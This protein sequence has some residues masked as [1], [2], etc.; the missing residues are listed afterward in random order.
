MSRDLAR[1]ASGPV[2]R[3]R[4]QP[5]RPPRT[6]VDDHPPWCAAG[7]HCTARHGAGEHASIP[8]VWRT[9]LGRFTATR[10][11]SS[12]GKRDHVELR[13]SLPLALDAD[14]DAQEQARLLIATVY[15]ALHEL[16]QPDRKE[17]RP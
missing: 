7:H 12:D 2:D 17:T 6:T 13:I 14:D 9:D 5:Y 10:Y 15:A 16:A 4:A 8:E 3:I 1:R 11:R